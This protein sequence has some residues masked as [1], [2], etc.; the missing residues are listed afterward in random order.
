MVLKKD[1]ETSLQQSNVAICLHTYFSNL[2]ISF[3]WPFRINK[4]RKEVI[5]GTGMYVV[6]IQLPS[7]YTTDVKEAMSMNK[8][9]KLVELEG[10]EVAA[11]LDEVSDKGIWAIGSGNY[12]HFHYFFITA[13]QLPADKQICMKI[14]LTRVMQ[15]VGLKPQLIKSFDYYEPGLDNIFILTNNSEH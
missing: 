5:E 13:S 11:Y 7:G 9:L 2:F 4:A 1:Y 8:H 10:E 6:T 3:I 15:V 14:K 12:I